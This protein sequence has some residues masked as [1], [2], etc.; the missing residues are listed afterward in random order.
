MKCVSLLYGLFLCFFCLFWCDGSFCS[1]CG[2]STSP[3]TLL[4]STPVPAMECH[5]LKKREMLQMPRS[6][7]DS[8]PVKQPSSHKSYLPENSMFA[9]FSNPTHCWY[10]LYIWENL[11]PGHLCS[12]LSWPVHQYW[13]SC[14]GQGPVQMGYNSIN[15]CLFCPNV[16]GA[17]GETAFSS[18]QLLFLRE[19]NQFS[20]TMPRSKAVA[21]L[22]HFPVIT[23]LCFWGFLAFPTF[24]KLYRN[25]CIWHLHMRV[26]L[27][28]EF[29]MYHNLLGSSFPVSFQHI[30]TALLSHSSFLFLWLC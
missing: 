1:F 6:F 28:L 16:N 18:E 9:I 12:W 19:Q 10:S 26:H 22:E 21:Q 4:L 13:W 29:K 3:K 5:C 30:L 8:R 23:N 17:K 15:L 14:V 24:F 20:M 7:C 2:I 11:V 27:H 25:S